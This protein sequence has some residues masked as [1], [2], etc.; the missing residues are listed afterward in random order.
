MSTKHQGHTICNECGTKFSSAVTLESHI[1]KEHKKGKENTNINP[2][3]EE[4]ADLE[5]WN[6]PRED[7]EVITEEDLA[8]LEQWN[9]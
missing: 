3:E 1:K 2:T 9:F 8:D 7:D 4:L 5:Q 6:F